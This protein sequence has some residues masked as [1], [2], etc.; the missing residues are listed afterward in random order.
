[1]SGLLLLPEDRAHLLLTMRRQ[2]PS[3]VHRRMNALL[4]LDDGW[5][6]EQV[7][8]ALFIDAE[9]VREHRRLYQVSGV[10]GIERPKYE[11]AASDLSE[12]QRAA[13][14]AELDA[15]LYMTAKAVC[16]FVQRSFAGDWCKTGGQATK[17][18]G[19]LESLAGRNFCPNSEPSVP[20]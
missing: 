1:M 7:A 15:R 17:A 11:G 12:K 19:G 14:G 13:L 4:L 2:T 3:P 6:A 16:A 9:T 10:A 5:T 18:A 8:K 20:L